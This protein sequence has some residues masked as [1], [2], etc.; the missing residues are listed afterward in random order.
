MKRPHKEVIGNATLYLGEA[1]A[2]L[3]E[4][5]SAAVGTVIS[6][7]P[8]GKSTAINFCGKWKG[9]GIA[10]DESNSDRDAALNIAASPFAI[11]SAVRSP[12]P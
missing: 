8:Y 1:L 12:W 3:Q 9:R 4:I 2:I 7:P 11:F 6:D 10:G 5:G